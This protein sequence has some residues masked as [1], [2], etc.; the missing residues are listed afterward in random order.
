LYIYKWELNNAGS[1][2]IAVDVVSENKKLTALYNS[3]GIRIVRS[4]TSI[5]C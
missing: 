5:Y 2:N 1:F 3:Q 4:N